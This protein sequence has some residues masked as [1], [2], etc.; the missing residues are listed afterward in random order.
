[1]FGVEPFEVVGLALEDAVGQGFELGIHA[2]VQGFG[3]FALLGQP[4]FQLLPLLGQSFVE[5]PFLFGEAFLGL[6]PGG[7]QPFVGNGLLTGNPFFGGMVQQVFTLAGCFELCF[8]GGC[9]SAGGQPADG[10]S[11]NQSCDE[12]QYIH[13]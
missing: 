4:F 6:L 9:F 2:A 12:C 10:T 1:M 13:S 8:D 11:R 5:V 3:L 7:F